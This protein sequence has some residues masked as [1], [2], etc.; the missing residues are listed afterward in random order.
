MTIRFR[1]LV[2]LALAFAAIGVRAEE[3]AAAP[4]REQYAAVKTVME[5]LYAKGEPGIRGIL[6]PK[7]N[8]DL[9]HCSTGADYLGASTEP[10]MSGFADIAF[11]NVVW[12][13]N[14]KKLN[15]PAKLWQQPLAEYEEKE[16]ARVIATPNEAVE[17]WSERREKVLN[18]LRD[19]I[20]AYRKTKSALRKV[21]VE[22]GCG[23]GEMSVNIATEPK[24]GQV[25]FIP[26]FFYELCRVQNLN[27]DDTSGCTRWREAVDGQLSA[28]SGD[29]LYIVRWPDGTTRRGKL[30]FNKLEDGQTV[31]LRKP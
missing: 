22:G 20:D 30:S 16:I 15:Y 17:G 3:P 27:P 11:D 26:T 4:T 6:S 9:Y 23:A 18:A 5:R 28:V 13:N 24:G 21:V 25:L 14:L 29:Y 10:G 7:G 8:Y 2:G 1:G 19:K 12:T 31:T